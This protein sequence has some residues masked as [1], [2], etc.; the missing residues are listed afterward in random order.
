MHLHVTCTDVDLRCVHMT[1]LQASLL[2]IPAIVQHG[3]SLSSEVWSRWYT[4]A[5]ILGGWA[6]RLQ[7][8]RERKWSAH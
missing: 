5:H 1:Y 8:H 7:Q 6:H 3:N 2:H 4:P